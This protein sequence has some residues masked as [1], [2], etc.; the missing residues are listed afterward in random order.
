MATSSG[1]QNGYLKL[2]RHQLL[3]RRDPGEAETDD[4]R[5]VEPKR[6]VAWTARPDA[7]EANRPIVSGS[8]DS[9]LELAKLM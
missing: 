4:G 8:I 1:N 3:L 7:R 5:S 2:I 6:W 9:V